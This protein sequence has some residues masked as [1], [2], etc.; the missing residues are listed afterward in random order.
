MFLFGTLFGF[1]L[2]KCIRK[3]PQK[4]ES[5]V[6]VEQAQGSVPLYEEIK[7]PSMPIDQDFLKVN[8][9]EAYSHIKI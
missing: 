3:S 1:L 7:L 9:N 8:A 4:N 2:I 6:H 5:S